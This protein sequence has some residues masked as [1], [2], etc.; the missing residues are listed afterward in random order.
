MPSIARRGGGE[1]VVVEGL[2]QSLVQIAINLAGCG[3]MQ[4]AFLAVMHVCSPGIPG[5]QVM[6]Q[7]TSDWALW[8]G[9]PL[10]QGTPV[11]Q[12]LLENYA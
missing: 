5:I 4:V 7:L 3:M 1:V 11:S 9:I 6:H 12:I 8:A 10:M 2:R